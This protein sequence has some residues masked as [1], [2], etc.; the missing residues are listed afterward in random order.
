MDAGAQNTLLL[1]TGLLAAALIG[2]TILLLVL[3]IGI[4][5]WLKKTSATVEQV[6]RNLEPILQT[7]REL[8]VETREKI[9][10]VTSNLSQISQLA[11]DQMVRLDGLVKDTTE[12]A[13]MQVV[14]LD[15]MVGETMNRVEETSEAIQRGV[16]KPVHEVSAVLAGVR[17]SMEFFFNRN[18]K[19]V[20]RA[21]QDEELFI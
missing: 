14:R 11:K 13:Q 1:F 8:L 20:E 2:Q 16:L 6:S 19:T 21:T 5:Q 15:H 10:A 7:S 4:R 17:A 12:R 9:S 18:R 3:V